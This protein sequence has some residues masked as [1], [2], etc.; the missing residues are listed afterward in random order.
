MQWSNKRGSMVSGS[1]FRPGLASLWIIL[2]WYL[3]VEGSLV[4]SGHLV[5]DLSSSSSTSTFLNKLLSNGDNQGKMP[6]DPCY[7]SLGKNAN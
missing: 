6:S 2:Q 3:V 4:S 7:D 5:N 1:N